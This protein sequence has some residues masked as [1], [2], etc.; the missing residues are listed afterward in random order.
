MAQPVRPRHMGVY[1]IR[2]T[3]TKTFANMLRGASANGT[4]IVGDPNAAP[5]QNR[6]VVFCSRLYSLSIFWFFF[7]FN[8]SGYTSTLDV[9]NLN[10]VTKRVTPMRLTS[11]FPLRFG[12]YASFIPATHND[13]RDP[14]YL[15]TRIQKSFESSQMRR[16]HLSKFG[17]DDFKF[18]LVEKQTKSNW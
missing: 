12:L 14:F 5:N 10:F 18:S 2:N 17:N 7:F 1:R 13:H 3:T 11:W 16:T 15:A 9:T 6:D 8:C 4:P